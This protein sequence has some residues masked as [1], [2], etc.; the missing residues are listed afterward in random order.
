MDA[1]ANPPRLWG[2]R[3]RLARWTAT[4]RTTTGTGETKRMEIRARGWA[5]FDRGGTSR[6]AGSTDAR[7]D[8]RGKSAVDGWMMSEKNI[9][10]QKRLT[11]DATTN[12][13]IEC[14][15]GSDREFRERF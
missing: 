4:A 11:S 10:G 2:V 12:G 14:T 9:R 13:S 8:A 1:R 6:D 3:G 5:V 7:R 15:Q